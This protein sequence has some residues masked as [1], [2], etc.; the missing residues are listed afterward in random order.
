MKRNK[1]DISKPEEVFPDYQ[2]K[3]TPDTML[4]YMPSIEDKLE[5]IPDAE[6]ENLSSLA[7]FFKKY[8]K[9][10]ELHPGQWEDGNILLG[11]RE[12]E[13][14]PSEPELLLCEVG[15]RLQSLIDGQPEAKQLLEN[16]K[17]FLDSDEYLKFTF[18]HM[19]V[20]GSGR[21]YYVDRIEKCK[22]KYR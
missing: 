7:S 18:I 15:E 9:E 19:D 12:R 5:K 17:I 14:R 11:A 16:D 6:I 4:D 2:P 13:Y 22:I 8:I 21:F 1:N 3:N 20:M 10:V